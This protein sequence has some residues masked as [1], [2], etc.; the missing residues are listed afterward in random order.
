[1]NRVD[2]FH[3]DALAI[4]RSV[5]ALPSIPAIVGDLL[6]SIDDPNA[7]TEQLAHK[8]AVDQ[9][10]VARLLRIANSSFYGLRRKVSSVQDAVFV[11]GMGNIRNLALAA[12]LSSS[13]AADAEASGMNLAAFWRHGVATAQCAKGL[14][15]RMNCSGDQ[16]FAAGLLHDIGRL[17]LASSFP[18]HYQEVARGRARRDC[19]FQEAE[20]EVLGIDHAA[21]GQ[22]LAER[23]GFPVALCEAVG[24]H[25]DPVRLASGSLAGVVHLADAIAH[26]LDVAGEEAELVPSIYPPCWSEARLS[27]ADSQPLFRAIERELGAFSEMFNHR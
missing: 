8:I 21:V 12:A 9:A 16:A 7:S 6:Q 4:S 20:I 5:D 10:L 22:H 15:G 3:L 1:M 27:W 26:A 19:L 24:G 18:K 11:L 17:V 25:H 13:F 23:W 14:A 2:Q